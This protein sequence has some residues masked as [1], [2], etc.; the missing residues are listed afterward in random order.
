MGLC[1]PSEFSS[2]PLAS[3]GAS[4]N[5]LSQCQAV[6]NCLIFF[7]GQELA[8]TDSVYDTLRISERIAKLAGGIAIINVGANTE[9]ELED[10]KLR[11]EDAKNA[12]FAAI[13]DGILPG[14]GTAF[15]K[16]APGLQEIRDSIE[17]EDERM[18]VDLVMQA[19]PE[20]CRMIARNAGVEGEVVVERVRCGSLCVCMR[21]TRKV[22]TP[23]GLPCLK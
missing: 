6:L 19:M 20:P 18:G 9:A 16:I 14:G 15:V 1:R 3:A 12:T 8:G 21:G 10:R 2:A 17:D 22:A 5:R 7:V 11:V 23:C 4:C 13:A